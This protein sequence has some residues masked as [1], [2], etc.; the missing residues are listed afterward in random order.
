MYGLRWVELR[1]PTFFDDIAGFINDRQGWWG[2][3]RS[4]RL[5]S[6]PHIPRSKWYGTIAATAYELGYSK[7]KPAFFQALIPPQD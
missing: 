6:I 7:S 4:M 1:N 2:C 5:A 3:N